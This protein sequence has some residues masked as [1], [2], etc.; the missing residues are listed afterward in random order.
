MVG[1][2]SKVYVRPIRIFVALFSGVEAARA[3]RDGEGADA[4]R[5][6]D[7]CSVAYSLS[8]M[9]TRTSLLMT[10]KGPMDGLQRFLRGVLSLTT[11]RA[12]DVFSVE[13]K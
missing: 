6:A 10:S 12:F 11:D 2:L 13:S 3:A 1:F 5:S 4:T 7:T 9:N 8:V